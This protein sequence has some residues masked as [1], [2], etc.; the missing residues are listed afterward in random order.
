MEGYNYE[1]AYVDEALQEMYDT[2]VYGEQEGEF[3]YYDWEE[4]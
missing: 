4:R 2:L 1:Y 3:E